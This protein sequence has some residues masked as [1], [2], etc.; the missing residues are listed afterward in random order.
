MPCLPATTERSESS[1]HAACPSNCRVNKETTNE[2][3]ALLRLPGLK[4]V[5]VIINNTDVIFIL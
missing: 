1:R 2:L 4:C 5:R 3:M